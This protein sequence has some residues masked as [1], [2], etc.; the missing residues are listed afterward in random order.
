MLGD[1]MSFKCTTSV[2]SFLYVGLFSKLKY[3]LCCI[4]ISTKEGRFSPGFVC[5]LVGKIPK[6]NLTID[7][8]E[9]FRKCQKWNH[10]QGE[11]D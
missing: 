7:F 4:I 2:L 1:K 11:P 6:K 10:E 9:I 5:L 8:D 3:S